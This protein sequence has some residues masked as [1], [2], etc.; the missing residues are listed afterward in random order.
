MILVVPLK[1]DLSVIAP[2]AVIDSAIMFLSGITGSGVHASF[3]QPLTEAWF[4]DSVTWNNQPQP[5]ANDIIGINN[6]IAISEAGIDITAIVQNWIDQTYI[7]HGMI[8][9]KQDET[10]QG[11]LAFASEDHSDST[12]H[13]RLDIYYTVKPMEVSYNISIDT[14]KAKSGS[15]ALRSTGGVSPYIY[16]WSSGAAS[17]TVNTLDFGVYAVTVTDA[18]GNF[19]IRPITVEFD[20]A[21][22]A[23]AGDKSADQQNWTNIKTY[24]YAK[25]GSVITQQANGE[26]RTYRDYFGRE[27][28][29]LKRL[30]TTGDK[31]LVTETLYDKFGRPEYI[32]LPAPV[33]QSD[34]DYIT[35]FAVFNTQSGTAPKTI[36]STCAL[37]QYYSD[38]NTAEPFVPATAYPYS[39]V[40][41]G[42]TQAGTVR[43]TSLAGEAHR[44][45]SGHEI[46]KFTL[47]TASTE[48]YSV[49]G[50]HGYEIN[51]KKDTFGL[52][53]DEY[54][55]LSFQMDYNTVKQVTVSPEGLEQI[56]YYD[57][58]GKLLATCISGSP[59]RT[60]TVKSKIG[61]NENFVDVHLPAGAND[62][63]KLDLSYGGSYKIINLKTDEVEHENIS[64]NTVQWI[65]DGAYLHGSYNYS[66]SCDIHDNCSCIKY[67]SSSNTTSQYYV[68]LSDGWTIKDGKVEIHIITCPDQQDDS[69]KVYT[70]FNDLEPGF[71]RIIY[72]RVVPNTYDVANIAAFYASVEVEYKLNYHHYS[73]NY[74][75]Q[76]GQLVKTLPP[77]GVDYSFDPAIEKIGDI[78]TTSNIEINYDVP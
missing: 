5:S 62:Y 32:T 14:S 29:S 48:L 77:A 6:I 45:G 78:M 51:R 54:D 65:A 49:Y 42:K 41:Y 8:L 43:R 26:T 12:L 44:L 18:W 66:G 13:P 37:G 47:P 63:L 33:T 64:F 57:L 34:M 58:S 22:Y 50:Y 36:N 73:L 10:T 72:E 75:N 23:K 69:Y 55:T 28:Q 25:S 52:D 76:A 17:S 67:V 20:L 35:N 16:R 1:F 53:T 39:Q 15:I 30:F 24:N 40:E 61:F 71:Y 19:A 46:W 27:T 74:Y 68:S 11:T 38:G 4:E 7:N 60:L 70:V 56:A 2:F 21:R 31:L 59:D 3:L 9:L